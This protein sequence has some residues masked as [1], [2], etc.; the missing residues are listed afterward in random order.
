MYV[1]TRGRFPR[2]PRSRMWGVDSRLE[3]VRE[4]LNVASKDLRCHSGS[5]RRQY[6]RVL[7]PGWNLFGYSGE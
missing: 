2:M 3:L 5:W 1:S 4:G 6:R 7:Q